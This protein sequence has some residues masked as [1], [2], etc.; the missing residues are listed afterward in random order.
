ML[1][2]ALYSAQHA[3]QQAYADLLAP[4]GLTY[5]QYLVMMSLWGQDGR[6]VGALGKELGLSSNTL[7]PLLKRM[8]AQGL[9]D[10]ARDPQ[11]ERRV[12]VRLTDAGQA[13]QDTA[14]WIPQRMADRMGL[15]M[16]DLVR[17]RGDILGVRD[18]LRA[19]GS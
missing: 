12:L 15:P 9:L 3:V 19:R 17:L 7:T 5:P 1:C 13:M 2:F 14:A 16:D 18:R 4:L 8:Q 10:R 6:S 11:D